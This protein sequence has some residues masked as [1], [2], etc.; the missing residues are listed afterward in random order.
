[1]PS[2]AGESF[3]TDFVEQFTALAT[4]TGGTINGLVLDLRNNHGGELPAATKFSS[5]FLDDSKVVT[6]SV[7]RGKPMKPIYAEKAEELTA[8]RKPI[9]A[10]TVKTLRHCPWSSSSMVHQQCNRSHS[11]STKGQYSWHYY[12]CHKLWQ[13]SRLQNPER[14]RGRA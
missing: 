1:M 2:F 12:W 7:L 5:L 14:T 13:R 10:N 11:R 9:D 3:I 8:D 6:Q 4:E